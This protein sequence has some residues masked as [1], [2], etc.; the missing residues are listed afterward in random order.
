MWLAGVSE[1]EVREEGEAQVMWTFVF[2]PMMDMNMMDSRA[3]SHRICFRACF[4]LL[5][6]GRGCGP[7]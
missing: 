6:Q 2:I 5:A 7:G 1:I 4:V 3:A